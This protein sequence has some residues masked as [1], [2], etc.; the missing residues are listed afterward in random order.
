MPAGAA[1]EFG[2]RIS[3]GGLKTG[4]RKVEDSNEMGPGMFQ[5]SVF[6]VALQLQSLICMRSRQC[7]AA[8]ERP[9]R[10]AAPCDFKPKSPCCD[11]LDGRAGVQPRRAACRMSWSGRQA[12]HMVQGG[13]SRI[14]GS[15]PSR[16][17]V[18]AAAHPGGEPS[19]PSTQPARSGSAATLVVEDMGMYNMD[20]EELCMDT[21]EAEA[22]QAGGAA[23]SRPSHDARVIPTL[24]KLPSTMNTAFGHAGTEHVAL[25]C[26]KVRCR[27]V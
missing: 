25:R 8:V 17:A 16:P 19:T 1:T 27:N 14:L 21:E 18:A 4:W 11:V 5:L 3:Q 2:K 6:S 26:L 12:P 20:T 10:C 24:G 15:Q 22:G 23:T 13:G 9:E 7:S